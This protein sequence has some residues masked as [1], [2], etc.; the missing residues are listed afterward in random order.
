M[1]VNEGAGRGTFILMANEQEQIDL[2]NIAAEQDCDVE[3]VLA[4]SIA[5]GVLV[6][7]FVSTIKGYVKED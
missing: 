1:K 7:G 2:A 5:L 6:L 3:F 4:Q